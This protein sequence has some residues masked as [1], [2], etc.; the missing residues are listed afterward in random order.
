MDAALRPTTG[1]APARPD[2]LGGGGAPPEI[3]DRILG[4]EGAKS[5]EAVSEFEA[6]LAEPDSAVAL[7]RW[8][9]LRFG[10]ARDAARLKD[11]ITLDIAQLDGLLTDQVNAILHHPVFQK[12]ESAWRGARYLVDQVRD[13][14]EYRVAVRILNVSWKEL[15]RDAERAVEFDQSALFHKVYDEEFGIAGGEPFGVLIGDY[16][17]RHRP[18]EQHPIDDLAVL[19]S[20]SHTAAAAFAPFISGAH[21][22]LLGLADYH[23]LERRVDLQRVFQ[24]AD[25]TKWNSFRKNDDAKFLGIALPHVLRRLPYSDSHVTAVRRFCSGCNARLSSAQRGH[26]PKC[27][28]PYDAAR[29]GTC[30]AQTLGFRFREDVEGPDS[31]KYLWGNA[32]FGFG[33]VLI[34]AYQSCGW[35]ADIRGFDR[36]VDGGG[37]VTGLP[38]HGFGLDSP[39]VAPIMNTQVVIDDRQEK[40]I[41]EHGLIPLCRC[42]DTEYSAFFSNNSL[43]KPAVYDNNEATLN[44]RI[45]SML[46]YTLC[47]SRFSHYLKVQMRD[48]LGATVNAQ[49]MEDDLNNWLN[50]YI[51]ADE[52]AKPEVRS[53]FPLRQ[54]QVEF[55]DIPGRPGHYQCVMKLWPH[56]QLDDL[57]ISVRMVTTAR[58]GAGR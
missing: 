28:Q 41:S 46:Q 6:F 55:R 44:A 27:Q 1:D 17:I 5:P 52:G 18:S 33:G 13:D 48:R 56:Y 22:S 43:H 40:E 42:H 7:G 9:R 45:S 20:I 10:S 19:E 21:P 8:C 35:L 29:G 58:V 37:I 4:G 14:E 36:N 50:D 16:E 12:L 34:R 54:A 53:R 49:S 30:T 51:T 23:Q 26:C 47:V 31:S 38:V 57:S 15:A 32:A 2:V 11:Q 25:Y 24:H 39:G 3:L